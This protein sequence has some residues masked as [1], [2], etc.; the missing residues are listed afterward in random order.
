MAPFCPRCGAPVGDDNLRCD[1]C[2]AE[3]DPC[4]TI[5]PPGPVG[6]ATAR[7]AQAARAV[8]RRDTEPA[9]SEDS[10]SAR[11][12]RPEKRSKPTPP[13][14]PQGSG[15][16]LARPDR[17]DTFPAPA[18]VE[19]PGGSEFQIPSPRGNLQRMRS[20]NRDF[21]L[22]HLMVRQ[23]HL[24]HALPHRVLSRSKIEAAAVHIHVRPPR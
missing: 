17:F 13:P 8:R 2:G 19:I 24:P 23:T 22:R 4:R 5:P 12:A 15:V 18:R 10:P 21:R 14:L 1:G 3:L 7:D 9:A 11:P 16:P 6:R 20:E